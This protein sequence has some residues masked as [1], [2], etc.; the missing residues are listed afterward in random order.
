MLA[1]L[2]AAALDTKSPPIQARASHLAVLLLHL[3]ALLAVARLAHWPLW[4]APV[5][6]T[7]GCLP[8][9]IQR[10]WLS[11]V[12][13]PFAILYGVAALRLLIVTVLRRTAPPALDYT[14]ALGFSAAWALLI[15]LTAFRR[16][17]WAAAL[18]A[19]GAAGLMLNLLWGH[20]AAG[21]TGSDPF[22][23]VQMALD[24]A[25]HGT[26]LHRFPLAVFAG[27]LE[28]PGM[29]APVEVRQL[30]RRVPIERQWR[31]VA[32]AP[33]LREPAR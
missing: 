18:A 9:L 20:A 2:R 10:R 17:R 6:L 29:E 4:S 28:L 33:A 15:A 8:S 31:R 11:E 27:G 13:A 25:Q 32:A 3:L 5:I 19:L 22:A 26:A 1:Q 14:W 30:L 21:V 24:L 23:Y 12:M 7:A 16:V